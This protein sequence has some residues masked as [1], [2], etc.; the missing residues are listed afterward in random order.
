MKKIKAFT[1][2]E[3]LFATFLFS[4]L[5]LGLYFIFIKSHSAWEK[6]NASLEQFQKIR[7]CFDLLKRDIKSTFTSPN[8]PLFIFNGEKERILFISSSNI[9]HEKGEYDLKQIEYEFRDFCLIRRVKSNLQ[10]PSNPGSSTV[11]ACDIDKLT[12]LYFNGKKWLTRW[13]SQKAKT[14]PPLP[15]A[16]KVEITLKDKEEDKSPLTFSSIISI[17]VK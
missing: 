9:P 14:F 13:N 4:V 11:I 17:P 10:D 3:I 6:G 15:Q 7:G 8:N 2:V 16:I 1:F 12:F 5:L